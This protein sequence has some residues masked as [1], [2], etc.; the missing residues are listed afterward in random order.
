MRLTDAEE[1]ELLQLLEAEYL[2]SCRTSFWTYCQQAVPKFY[3]PHRAYLRKLCDDLQAFVERRLLLPNGEV[4]RKLAINLPPRLGKTLT[5]EL[6]VC[7]T[8]GRDP[9]QSDIV[10]SYNEKLS[11]KFAKFV[12]NTI[13]E[14]KAVAT[15]TVF[16]DVFPGVRVKKGDGSEHMWSLEGSHFSFLATS[17]GATLTGV[18]ATGLAIIDDMI[19]SAKEAFNARVL[20]ER[21]DWY[22]DTY[23]S[24]IEAASCLEIV[25]M[26]R[27]T[28]GDLCGRLFAAEGDE[29]YQ[30][31]MPAFNEETGE[32]LAPDLLS[33][34]RYDSLQAKLDPVIFA[35]N[36]Q[37]KPFDSGDRLYATFK[38]YKA[39]DL[40]KSFERIENYTDTA[41]EG[42]DYLCSGSYGVS[43][44]FA[45]MLDVLYT[46]DPM[47]RT[48]PA[49]AR[50]L[51]NTK[52]ERAYIESNNGGRGFARNVGALLI[53][54]GY[55]RCSVDWFH[56]G[57]NKWAR[58]LTN[59]TSVTNCIIMPEGWQF[60]WP[61]FYAAVTSCTRLKPP[62]H[63]DA[64]DFLSGVVE[65]SLSGGSFE[66]F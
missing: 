58:I 26:T 19:K 43:E 36:Y 49:T 6:L 65:K 39:E 12:R 59:A 34:K 31:V 61:A 13:Q 62:A 1:L 54:N 51:E 45:Y 9:S 52:T 15:R 18:G 20:E 8:L 24:R 38:I 25:I 16:A 29:W 47:E 50:L 27:W 57:E 41:D 32:M 23:Q 55:S 2:E 5:V 48:E 66:I 46:Q 64:P 17:P 40:P 63:D 37:Q 56:Q 60:R 35:G 22:N 28:T 10:V 33:R 53:R 7:W 4:A 21:W 30:I 44:G 14:I 3:K 11:T 42:N